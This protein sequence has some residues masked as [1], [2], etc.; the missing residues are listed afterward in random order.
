MFLE[1]VVVFLSAHPL[2]KES[3]GFLAQKVGMFFR[4]WI[5]H[6]V[7][8]FSNIWTFCIFVFSG[9]ARFNDP[10]CSFHRNMGFQAWS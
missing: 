10:F 6:L 9:M 8:E 4:T 1:Q 2:I 7:L 5:S 3:P